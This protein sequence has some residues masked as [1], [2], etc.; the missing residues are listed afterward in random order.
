[1]IQKVCVGE[2]GLRKHISEFRSLDKVL[3][4]YSTICTACEYKQ[5]KLALEIKKL[6]RKTKGKK[7]KL[8]RYSKPTTTMEEYNELFIKQNGCCAICGIHQGKL[9]KKLAKDHCHTTG[10]NRGLLCGNCNLALG[11]LKENPSIMLKMMIYV[12]DHSIQKPGN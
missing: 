1:M 6:E 5:N 3:K 12:D 11:L 8:E 10:K 7:S 9:N 4:K 2:C